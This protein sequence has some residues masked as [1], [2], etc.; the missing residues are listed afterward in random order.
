MCNRQSG[1]TTDKKGDTVHPVNNYK[2]IRVTPSPGVTS[3]HIRTQV[4]TLQIWRSS[5]HLRGLSQG[6][7]INYI[8]PFVFFPK[9]IPAM[10]L[11]NRNRSVDQSYLICFLNVCNPGCFKHP[12]TRCAGS[13]PPFHELS[14]L[15][16]QATQNSST[17]APP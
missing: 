9:K 5:A 1:T 4:L 16:A 7:H 13:C 2:R 11:H 14:P 10:L 12:S 3:C 15:A 17:P 6:S 8:F